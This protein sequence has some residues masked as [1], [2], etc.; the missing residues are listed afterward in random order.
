MDKSEWKRY[1]SNLRKRRREIRKAEENVAT[2]GTG[3]LL[4]SG[5]GDVQYVAWTAIQNP[6]SFERLVREE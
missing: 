4:I 5:D 3:L 2:F 6:R 1:Y